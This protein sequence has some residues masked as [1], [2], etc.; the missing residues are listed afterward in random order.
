MRNRNDKLDGRADLP[1]R[2][3]LVAEDDPALRAMMV[4][5]LAAEGHDV[6]AVENGLDLLDTIEV[7]LVPEL[8]T[9]HFDLVISDVRMREMTGL[10]A[11][12]QLG[13][14]PSVPPVVFITA[15]GDEQLRE[16]ATRA[17]ALAVLDKPLDFDELLTFVRDFF[18]RKLN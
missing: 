15:F 1:M 18:S 5:L 16:E 8:G 2:R 3:L 17:G 4:A 9:R 11:F 10:R 13:S 7:S 14:R 12:A 6:V